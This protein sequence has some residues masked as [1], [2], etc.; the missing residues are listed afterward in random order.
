LPS[1]GKVFASARPAC[2]V[3]VASE[4]APSSSVASLASVKSIGPRSP[5]RVPEVVAV[6]VK[7]YGLGPDA[8]RPRLSG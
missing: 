8:V 1:A 2:I 4:A 5:V 7:V 6:A 3:G